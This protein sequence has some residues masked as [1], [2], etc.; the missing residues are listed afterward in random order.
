MAAF[1]LIGTVSAQHVRKSDGI[2]LQVP[3]PTLSDV[4]KPYQT[5]ANRAVVYEEGFESTSGTP[6]ASGTNPTYTPPLPTGWTLSY[7]G[8]GW[9]TCHNLSVV[10]GCGDDFEPHTG[11]RM[12]YATWSSSGNKW[13]FTPGIVLEAGT[14]YT[15][16]FWYNAMGWAPSEPDNFEVK[17]GNAANATGMTNLVF[18][19]IG[20][21]YNFDFIWRNATYNF[22]PTDAGTY[23]LG[24]HDLRP[25]GTGLC[26]MIDD[27]LIT[28]VSGPDPCPAVT[29][30]NT[31]IF[32]SNKVKVAWTAPTVT[33]NLTGYEVYQDN[34]KKTTV[35]VGTTL[36]NSDPLANGI[37]KFE[38]AA[39]YSG[40]CVPVK[41]AAADVA[42]N[43]CDK[44]VTGLAVTYAADCET[45]TIAWNAPVKNRASLL[46]DNG[47]FVTHPGQGSG[48]ADA[49]NLHSN[50]TSFGTNVNY[51]APA[52][53]GPFYVADD[54]VLTSDA[55][56][57]YIEFFSYISF[58]TATNP[59]THVVVE[60]L[61]GSPNAGGTVVGGDWT[62]NR[63][64]SATFSNVFR[65]S[66]TMTNTDRRIWTVKANMGNL[67]LSAG[68]YWVKV[69]IFGTMTGTMTGPWTPPVT[70]PTGVVAGNALSHTMAAPPGWRPFSTTDGAIQGA[71]PFK[72]YGESS[73]PPTPEYNVYRGSEKIA[74][75][76][77]EVTFDDK[78][79]D[80]TQ[81]YTW[82]VAVICPSGDDGLWV[83][84]NMIACYTPPP[85]CEPVTG[86]KAAYDL[87]V[88]E[89]KVNWTAP[90]LTPTGYEVFKDGVSKEVVNVT[91]YIEDISE[92]DPGDYEFEYC[93]LPLYAPGICEGNITED[94]DETSF[95]IIGIKKYTTTFSIVPNPAYNNIMIT[96]GSSFNS[97]EVLNFLG[98]VVITQPNIG[99]SAKLDISNLT[100]GVY[101]VRVISDTGTSVKKFVKQ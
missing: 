7:T 87:D 79:F 64:V 95:T 54:F 12:M 59:F 38:I 35:P 21:L 83:S 90:A 30:V 3:T 13:A 8:H 36:W 15:I 73:T 74:G 78:T 47:G 67:A 9:G 24:F 84:E 57:D 4:A 99:T 65:V 77:E 61:N 11:N 25:T 100:N 1:L 39:I 6:T 98:Q 16:S 49:S 89:I 94:C 96:S 48:G 32:E 70:T 42:I 20:I 31:T 26:I 82:S 43:I 71:L 33:T 22:T 14:V 62:T 55:V 27:I 80:K 5:P 68:T 92:L 46:F 2:P 75:P 41:V 29:N 51:Q 52:P 53:N 72:I 37:Y 60:I 93:V 66:G 58:A 17:I 101:F 97:V 63:Y 34:V 45:T 18:S 10:P 76:I 86:V 85:P 28:S 91:E 19:Q 40:D 50:E 56:I 44:V 81:P 88:M 23:Y 69:G